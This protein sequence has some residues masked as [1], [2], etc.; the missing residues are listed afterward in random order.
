L[1][2]MFL[3]FPLCSQSENH[4]GLAACG[5]FAIFFEGSAIPPCGSARR[6]MC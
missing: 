6:G 5:G 3:I 4:P 2:D 1:L